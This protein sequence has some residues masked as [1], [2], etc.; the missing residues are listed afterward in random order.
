[1]DTITYT[2]ASYPCHI[3]GNS[4]EIDYLYSVGDLRMYKKEETTADT[5]EEYYLKNLGIVDMTTGNWTWY[6]N[7]ADRVAKVTP[8]TYQQPDAISNNSG[9]VDTNHLDISFYLYDHLGNTRVVY[10][11][12]VRACGSVDITLDYAGDYYPYG[13]ILRE[14]ANGP[15]E[16]YLTTQHERDEE[17]GLDYRGARFYDSDIGRF[18]STDPV[19]HDDMSPYNALDG[20]PVYYIDPSGADSQDHWVIG[21]DG[22]VEKVSDQGGSDY[23]LFTFGGDITR[24][25]EGK[26]IGISNARGTRVLETG[27]QIGK[28]FFVGPFATYR[29]AD[30]ID[31]AVSNVDLWGNVPTEYLGHYD[32]FSLTQRYSYYQDHVNGISSTAYNNVRSQEKSGLSRSNMI[33]SMTDDYNYIVGKYGSDASLFMAFEYDM[34]PLP[35]GGG[36]SKSGQRGLR[37][38]KAF[39]NSKNI[40]FNINGMRKSIPS[41]K[42]SWRRFLKANR[43]KYR[44][45]G[46]GR[47]WLDDAVRDYNRAKTEGL[48]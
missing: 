45:R 29:G 41:D 32:M 25:D 15:T 47:K 24:N 42:N 48:F 39:G 3:T 38:L 30:E 35:G 43:G 18:N 6:I 5:V 16:R 2:R 28:D 7:G 10:T 26:I 37:G 17:T 20:N 1:M 4:H 40:Q 44:G 27:N 46:K 22:S 19:T 33:W 23:Q 9:V 11:P 13:K 36:F 14:Y 31:Y 8:R 12:E 21:D 34:M